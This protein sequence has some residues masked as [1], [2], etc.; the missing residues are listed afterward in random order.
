MPIFVVVVCL[1]MCAIHQ[2]ISKTQV[3]GLAGT[4][5]RD[6]ILNGTTHSSTGPNLAI[7]GPVDRVYKAL[8]QDTTSIVV[9][10]KP[11]YDVIRDNLADTVIW[12]PWQEGA[13]GM[14]D[15]EPKDG[16][17]KMVCVEAG[18]VDGWQTLDSGDGFEAGQI[19]KSY[20]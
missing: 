17:K 15:F 13:A 3:R 9:D 5:Y 18:A 4:E 7:A 12:N 1:T 2:D 8:K 6:K 10:D 14:S 11:A 19:L 20:L 16:W